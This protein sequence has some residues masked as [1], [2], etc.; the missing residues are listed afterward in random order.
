MKVSGQ[1]Q[2]R[3][4]GPH[5]VYEQIKQD[6]I[7]CEL[8]PGQWINDGEL[9]A[10]FAVSKTPIREALSKLE[11]DNLVQRVSRKGYQVTSVTLRDIQEIY[12]TR[13]IIER[14]TALLAADRVTDDEIA[15]LQ[16]LVDHMSSRLDGTDAIRE[17]ILANSAFH[18]GVARA[19]RNDRLVALLQRVLN[20]CQRSLEMELLRH[21]HATIDWRD[22]HKRILK[23]LAGREREALVQAIEEDNRVWLAHLLGANPPLSG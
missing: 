5:S 12:E 4:G 21:P 1:R 2:T 8:A 9:A 18:L 14:G 13:L 23:A 10:K 15:R 11:E 20:E 19:S 7:C 16:R 22:S 3:V 6:I 17:L